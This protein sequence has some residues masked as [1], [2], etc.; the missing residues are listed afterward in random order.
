MQG[1][2]SVTMKKVGITAAQCAL[3]F[4]SAMIM[5][6]I[7]VKEDDTEYFISD[8][9]NRCKDIGISA[10]NLAINLQNLLEFSRTT[11]PIPISGIDDYPREKME[12]KTGLEREMEGLRQPVE[13][14]DSERSAI[15]NLQ[16]EA[17]QQQKMIAFDLQ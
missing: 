3:G 1:E 6:K 17:L 11:S 8:I 7:G 4:R 16:V 15:T 14:L 2:P 13:D 5:N 12:Q 10:E 9:Y